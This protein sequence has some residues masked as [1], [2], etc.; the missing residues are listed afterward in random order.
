MFHHSQDGLVKGIIWSYNNNVFDIQSAGKEKKLY[1]GIPLDSL[2][3]RMQEY[4]SS[5]DE[6]ADY[7]KRYGGFRKLQNKGGCW[8]VPKGIRRSLA[9]SIPV[10]K[11]TYLRRQRAIHPIAERIQA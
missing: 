3:Y 8:I 2:Y 5:V 1:A 10:D 9:E 7:V 4:I 6:L 11:A